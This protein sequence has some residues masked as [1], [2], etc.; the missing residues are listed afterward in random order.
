MKFKNISRKK[1]N[2]EYNSG[3]VLIMYNETLCEEEVYMVITRDNVYYNLLD[4][5]RGVIHFYD[6]ELYDDFV[7][8]LGRIFYS[9]EIISNNQLELVRVED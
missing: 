6:F 9:I 5:D 2:V 4:L 3:E 8:K 1:E 7:K